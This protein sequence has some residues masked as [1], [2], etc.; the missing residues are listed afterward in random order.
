MVASTAFPD[1]AGVGMIGV[2]RATAND[3]PMLNAI[4]QS[5]SAYGGAYRVMIEDYVIA[6]EQIVRDEMHVAEDES[7]VL[8]F[9][10]LVLGE[11]PELDLLFV[12]DAAQGR[13]VGR[14]LF[15]HMRALAASRGVSAVKI[16]SHPPA[17]G[18]YRGMGAVGVGWAYPMGAATWV[19]PILS[20][21]IAPA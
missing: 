5:S 2:R 3:A 17:L 6:P 4:V 19:R 21:T 8:G 12:T 7:D 1:N 9:Y 15:D 20:L 11:T 18:F 14:I 16:V 13:G 10:S